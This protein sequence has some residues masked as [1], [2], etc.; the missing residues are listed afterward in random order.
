MTALEDGVEK[1]LISE[2]EIK[3]AVARLGS[4]ITQDYSGKKLILVSILKGAFVFLADLMREIKIPCEV[5]FMCVSS[6]HDA[7]FSSGSVTLIKDLAIDIEGYDVLIVEDILDSGF[8]LQNVLQLLKGRKP[9]SLKICTLLDKPARR[10]VEVKCDY[11]GFEVPDEFVIG[12][13]LDCAEKYR[14][15]RYIGVYSPRES[16]RE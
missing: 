5:D 9:A 13:G 1:V 7:T 8:T 16:I 11:T 6:Y 3:S 14:N 4:V 2:D 15:L 10:E 12:Y